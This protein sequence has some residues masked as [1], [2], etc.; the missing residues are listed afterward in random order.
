M[1]AEPPKRQRRWFQ[2]SLRM[3]FV[4]GAIGVFVIGGSP[5]RLLVTFD[6]E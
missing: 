2:F 1:P 3:L 4:V 6:Q 5:R